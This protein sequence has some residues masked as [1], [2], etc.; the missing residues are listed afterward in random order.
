MSRW[1][2]AVSLEGDAAWGRGCW[3]DIAATS[4]E[5]RR[6]QSR[7]TETLAIGQDV[8]WLTIHAALLS[9]KGEFA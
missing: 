1:R 7:P 2:T 8:T 9:R 6:R 5:Q 3:F 4:I